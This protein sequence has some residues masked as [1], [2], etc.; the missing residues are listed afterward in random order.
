ML[1]PM[2]GQMV[3]SVFF[4]ANPTKTSQTTLGSFWMDL[5]M[6][7]GLEKF[8]LIPLEY[9]VDFMMWI[10]KVVRKLPHSDIHVAGFTNL[11]IAIVSIGFFIFCINT[12]KRIKL[13]GL[14]IAIAGC[15]FV[16]KKD[17]IILL[18]STKAFAV[19][20]DMISN[21]DDKKF[22]FSSR[23]R[24]RFSQE[25]WQGKIGKDNFL[26]ES[27]NALLKKK[28]FDITECNSDFCIVKNKNNIILFI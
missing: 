5:L 7:F 22:I 9:S 1:Y 27:L 13:S 23:Q 19:R 8:T 18:V 2:I 12:Q 14:I 20:H 24:D 3:F 6:P 4:G 17:N 25:V 16:H 11:G 26:K 28:K 10:A 21:S 15:F